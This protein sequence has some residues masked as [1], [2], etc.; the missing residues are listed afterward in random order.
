MKITAQDLFK[1]G[2]IDTIVVEPV[3]GAHRDHE[4][5]AAADRRRHSRAGRLS[6]I[7][8]RRTQGVARA[9]KFLTIGRK[10]SA[11]DDFRRG[12]GAR[13]ATL[14]LPCVNYCFTLVRN[15]GR[16]YGNVLDK[17]TARKLSRRRRENPFA[18]RARRRCVAERLF[19]TRRFAL[20]ASAAASFSPAARRAASAPIAAHSSDPIAPETL[21]LMRK[22]E[23]TE[24]FARS[25]SAPIRRNRSS[26]SGR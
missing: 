15:V 10:P 12:L 25:S 14:T 19:A 11:T 13:S 1:F 16:A 24:E 6:S 3:G 23:T 18:Q 9:E 8:R 17:D 26:K 20:L 5:P 21:A 2:I 22:M 4:A 7:C